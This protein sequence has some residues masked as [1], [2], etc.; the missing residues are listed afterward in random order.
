MLRIAASCW[1]IVAS[2]G[3]WLF[4]FYILLFYGKTTLTS[5]FER[6]NR[7]LPHG[8][9]AG[10]WVG[11]LIVG[12]HVLLASI[13]VIGGP[14]QLLPWVRHQAPVFH[15]RLGQLYLVTAIVVSIAGLVMVWTRGS[16]GDTIQHYSIS[17]QAVYIMGFAY[18]SI[19]YAKA[20]QFN[21]HR[22]WALRLFMVTNGG[23]F[24][25]VGLMSWLVINGGP[26]GFDPQS[27]TG[28]FL[29]FL[30]VFTYAIPLSVVLLELYLYACQTLNKTLNY[31]VSATIF[32]VTLLTTIGIFG[33]TLGLWFPQIK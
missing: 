8:Y 22:I 13:L 29:T 15:R 9:V 18:Q 31:L 3:Q 4:G 20:R 25:R 30:A 1:L 6:W 7:V 16:V 5:D 32:L 2:V 26:V 24:F 17:L 28:P 14:I 33:A 27:F 21:Q 11:N 23:W 12:I 10:D 19:R